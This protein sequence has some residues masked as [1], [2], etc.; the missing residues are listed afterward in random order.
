MGDIFDEIVDEL[1]ISQEEFDDALN[2]SLVDLD[3][4][5]KIYLSDVYTRK[6]SLSIIS[7]LLKL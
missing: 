2:K 6:E 5:E 7:D 1:E 4:I 3:I